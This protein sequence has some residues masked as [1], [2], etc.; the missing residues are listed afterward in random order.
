MSNKEK[1]IYQKFNVSR[2]DGGTDIGEKHCDCI[3]FVLDINHDPHGRVALK[4]YAESCA[5]EYP[6]LSCDLL[7]LL[8]AETMTTTLRPRIKRI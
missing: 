3:H 6:E 2:V 5:D 1:G 4:A 8:K 7:L